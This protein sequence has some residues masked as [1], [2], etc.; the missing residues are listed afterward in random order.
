MTSRPMMAVSATVAANLTSAMRFRF[1]R[2]A[3][4]TLPMATW[5]LA[6]PSEYRSR[7]LPGFSPG[8]EVGNA[9]RFASSLLFARVDCLPDMLT[10]PPG[11]PGTDVWQVGKKRIYSL[12]THFRGG[13]PKKQPE[14][15]SDY[16]TTRS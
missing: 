16:L 3:R 10:C 5:R 2:I 1:S 12:E 15:E 4:K 7:V 9:L 6:A 8:T 14:G 13:C 11:P